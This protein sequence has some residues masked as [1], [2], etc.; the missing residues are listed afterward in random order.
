M[1]G[2]GGTQI[3]EIKCIDGSA[4]IQAQ[5]NPRNLTSPLLSLMTPVPFSPVNIP[6]LGPCPLDLVNSHL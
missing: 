6:H 3:L 2:Y 4:I 5:S 1:T